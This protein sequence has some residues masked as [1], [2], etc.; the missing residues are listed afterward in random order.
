M[1]RSPRTGRP[2]AQQLDGFRTPLH[3]VGTNRL[4]V[5]PLVVASLAIAGFLYGYLRFTTDSVWP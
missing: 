2:G 3:H 4:G 1:R 5:I